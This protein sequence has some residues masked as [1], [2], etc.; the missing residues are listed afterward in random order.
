MRM[1]SRKNFIKQE[2][3]EA[4]RGEIFFAKWRTSDG[5]V[6]ESPCVIVGDKDD[7]YDEIL[8]CKITT[9]GPKTGYDVFLSLKFDSHIRVSKIY[10]IL[11]KQLA[12]KIG[13]LDQATTYVVDG[14]LKEVLSLDDT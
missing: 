5:Y 11:R 13:E 12:F 10:T 1:S 2:I 6:R 3:N 8:I 7:P 9:S 14:Y 4:S